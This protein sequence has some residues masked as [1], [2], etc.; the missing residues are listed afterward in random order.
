[1]RRVFFVLFLVVSGGFPVGWFCDRIGS[2][3]LWG[4]YEY[5]MAWAMLL[6]LIMII[7]GF[8][9]AIFFPSPIAVVVVRPH[10]RRRWFKW[11]VNRVSNQ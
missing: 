1:M 2:S 8:L 3:S 6:M 9:K 5:L 11:L 7:Y 10:R 4:F